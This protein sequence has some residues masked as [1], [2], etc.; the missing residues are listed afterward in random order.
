[1]IEQEEDTKVITLDFLESKYVDQFV[2]EDLESTKESG[3]LFYGF[4]RII[5]FFA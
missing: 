5:I 3:E 1:M 2:R 4:W